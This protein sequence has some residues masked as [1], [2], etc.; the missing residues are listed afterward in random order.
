M[1]KIILLTAC[2]N[3]NGMALTA[4][5]DTD[6]R[7]RQ[8]EGA[9]NWYLD[10][11]DL[12]ILFVENTGYDISKRYLHQIEDGRLEVLSFNGNI[13]PRELGKGYGEAKIL[14]YAL[15]HSTS[16]E[17][18]DIV[19]KITGRLICCNVNTIVK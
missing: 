15:N 5:Q 16:L 2:V 14:E 3:P 11:T 13:Y 6:E 1:N 4:L 9:L 7:L 19:I 18:V 8:Y 17:K 10:N 12:P